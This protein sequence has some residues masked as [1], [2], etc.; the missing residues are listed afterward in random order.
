M[1]FGRRRF[2]PQ[3]AGPRPDRRE[4]VEV[5]EAGI[6]IENMPPHMIIE[7]SDGAEL[8]LVRLPHNMLKG[9]P[10]G[11]DNL[12]LING[13]TG[14]NVLVP[15]DRDLVVGRAINDNPLHLPDSASRYRFVIRRVETDSFEIR[16]L[17]RTNGTR[18]RFPDTA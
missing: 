3:E 15:R 10:S 1:R 8:S 9:Q 18:L 6:V 14:D 4:T 17:S 13:E 7:L 16:N 5:T 12:H 2:A 11:S